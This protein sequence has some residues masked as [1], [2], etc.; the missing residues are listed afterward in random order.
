VPTGR[1][2]VTYSPR[3]VWTGLRA[4]LGHRLYPMNLAELERLTSEAGLVIQ[5]HSRS[6]LQGQCLVKKP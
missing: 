5:K 4:L 2:V 1:A 6:L 3:S